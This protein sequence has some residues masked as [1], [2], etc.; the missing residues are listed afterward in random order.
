MAPPWVS[1]QDHSVRVRRKYWLQRLWNTRWLQEG[2]EVIGF[3]NLG[4]VRLEHSVSRQSP[5]NHSYFPDV[6][7]HEVYWYAPWS[8][9]PH[10][11]CSQYRTNLLNSPFQEEQAT[12]IAPQ[13]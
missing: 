4:L 3:N 2:K 6:V 13:Q 10:V 12:L 11:V 1:R 8:D 9:T 7:I 5:S